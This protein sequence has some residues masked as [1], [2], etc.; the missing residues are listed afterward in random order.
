MPPERSL[1]ERSLVK[2]LGQQQKRTLWVV[3]AAG[4]VAVVPVLRLVLDLLHDEDRS[5]ADS[6]GRKLAHP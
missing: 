1:P 3:V 6:R 2:P 4:A 5:V